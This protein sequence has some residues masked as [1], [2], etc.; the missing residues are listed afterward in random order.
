MASYLLVHYRI[1]AGYLKFF[2][3]VRVPSALLCALF[4]FFFFATKFMLRPEVFQP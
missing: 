1:C 2:L 4:F 3:V